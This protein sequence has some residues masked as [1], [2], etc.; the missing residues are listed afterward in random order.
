[1]SPF[2]NCKL[3]S[4]KLQSLWRWVMDNKISC[5]AG[6]LCL[7]ETLSVTLTTVPAH[8]AGSA[9]GPWVAAF[10]SCA[11]ATGSNQSTSLE[12]L[13]TLRSDLGLKAGRAADILASM[14]DPE[15][16]HREI[17]EAQQSIA[18]TPYEQQQLDMANGEVLRLQARG[19]FGLAMRVK[20]RNDRVLAQ[21]FGT[22]PR[23]DALQR[24]QEA[25]AQLAAQGSMESQIR[26][27]NQDYER[28]RVRYG[29]A[30][31]QVMGDHSSTASL[32]TYLRLEN[33]VITYKA[34]RPVSGSADNAISLQSLATQAGSLG[35]ELSQRITEAMKVATNS[36]NLAKL[37]APLR[38]SQTLRLNPVTASLLDRANG[39]VSALAQKERASEQLATSRAADER[40]AA[41]R[42]RTAAFLREQQARSVPGA[43]NASEIAMTMAASSARYSGGSPT[44]IPGELAFASPFGGIQH[45]V[46]QNVD[47][48]VC[49]RKQV[50]T[51]SCSYNMTWSL[52]GAPDSFWG[53]M[54][55]DFTP[56][57]QS[58][59]SAVFHKSGTRWISSAVDESNRQ[60]AQR[61]RD[62]EQQPSISTSP[63]EDLYK[64]YQDRENQMNYIHDVLTYRPYSVQ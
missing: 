56:A 53:K 44:S 45:Y 10:Q 42:L 28:S 61:M 35:P 11:T 49:T 46:R 13:A 54:V 31:G 6:L 26:G 34:C 40:V 17:Y 9:N 64:E 63:S 5:A 1:M 43:P 23:R 52:I 25:E 39:A 12:N 33:E 24:K 14:R 41:D 19:A 51:Y 60:A 37:L 16:L 8:A 57:Q 7:V 36:A 27:L 58:R 55:E 48:A 50:D 38:A 29:M 18:L 62:R 15:Q 2:L 3:G 22:G 30:I 20:E 32:G 21:I 47:T 4:E 59:W